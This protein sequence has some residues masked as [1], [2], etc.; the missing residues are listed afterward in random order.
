MGYSPSNAGLRLIGADSVNWK[1]D[2]ECIESLFVAVKEC[3][4]LHL[5]SDI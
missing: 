3:A 1:W 2:L 4:N 5:L